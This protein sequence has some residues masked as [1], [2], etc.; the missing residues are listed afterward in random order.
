[1][2]LEGLALGGLLLQWILSLGP[3]ELGV[4]PRGLGAVT[5]LSSGV[6]VSPYAARRKAFSFLPDR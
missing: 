3:L 5:P 4:L 6:A 2:S 1:M